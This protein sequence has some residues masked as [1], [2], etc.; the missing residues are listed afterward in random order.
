MTLETE[1]LLF[2]N[3]EIGQETIQSR[4]EVLYLFFVVNYGDDKKM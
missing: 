4:N 2:K 1:I 3:V